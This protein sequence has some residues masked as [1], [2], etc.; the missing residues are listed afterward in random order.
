MRVAPRPH[1]RGSPAPGRSPAAVGIPDSAHTPAVRR[2]GSLAGRDSRAAVRGTVAGAGGNSGEDSSARRTGSP[3]AGPDPAAAGPG[4]APGCSR[5]AHS[6]VG[7]AA[8]DSGNLR[9]SGRP[10][11]SRWR[12]STDREPIGRPAWMRRGATPCNWQAPGILSAPKGP[13]L[14][15]AEELA[16]V[17][18]VAHRVVRVAVVEDRVHLAGLFP[19][20]TQVGE[21]GLEL[22]RLVV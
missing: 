17:L 14:S 22:A 1:S 16:Q 10:V 13:E 18:G 5:E 3:A 12:R 11:D 21:P 2:T 19:H 9:R 8:G 20:V 15:S 6:R 4:T 7:E